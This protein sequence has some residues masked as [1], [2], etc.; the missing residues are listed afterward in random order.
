MF[1]PHYKCNRLAV[2]AH[3]TC[4][5]GQQREQSL[6]K[7]VSAHASSFSRY[8]CSSQH[9][10]HTRR[11]SQ[12]NG[13]STKHCRFNPPEFKPPIPVYAM[14]LHSQP[15]FDSLDDHLSCF[16]YLPF[17]EIPSLIGSPTLH[18]DPHFLNLF[19]SVNPLDDP[20]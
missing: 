6:N 4:Q 12:P 17:E 15:T 20:L 2:N 14:I 3:C 10:N 13:T 9:Q 16:E 5:C 1:Y 7:P 8:S 11:G 19:S 18:D